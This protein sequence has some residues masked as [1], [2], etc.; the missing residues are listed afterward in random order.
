MGKYINKEKNHPLAGG[1]TADKAKVSGHLFGCRR[2][3]MRGLSRYKIRFYS[4]DAIDVAERLEH[5]TLD[6]AVCLEP[7]DAARYDYIS[8][9]DSS[10]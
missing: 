2:K 6:F 10:K 9:P 5:G 1:Q 8:L 4:S 7:V 3:H